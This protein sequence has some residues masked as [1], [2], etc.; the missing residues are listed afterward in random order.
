MD[1]LHCNRCF[2]TEAARLCVSSCGHTCCQSCASPEKCGV[3]GA[4]CKYLLLSDKMKAQEQVYF[5]D[6]VELTQNRLEHLTQISLFQ[7]TQMVRVLSFFKRKSSELERRLEEVC[8]ASHR[9]ISELR[10]EN[11]ELK[12]LLSQRGVRI[13]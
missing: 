12:R 4:P 2:R 5:R 11:S 8:K 1:W 6:T 10:K 7:K 13:E 9:E 3:C